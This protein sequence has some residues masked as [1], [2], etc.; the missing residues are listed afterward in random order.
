MIKIL[1]VEDE[2]EKRRLLV[3]TLIAVDGINHD[4][5]HYA[6]DVRAAKREIKETRFEL[7]ILDINIPMT[8][9]QEAETGAG[10]GVLSF[11]KNNLAAK[12][13]AF[14]VG[15]TSYDDGVAAAEKEFSSPLWKLVR[16]S[17]S[18]PTWQ[19][20]LQEAIKY[21][22]EKDAP[23]YISDGNTYHT[24]LAIFV[25]LEDE[26]LDSIRRLDG[27]WKERRIV[28]DNSRY[29]EGRFPTENG[30]ISV[31]AVAAPKMGLPAAAVIAS[32]LIAAYRPRYIA[33]TGICAGVRDKVAIGDILVAEPCFDWG[34][35]KWVRD[36]DGDLKFRP[37]P[38]PWRLDEKV[39]S[40]IKKLGENLTF[41]S[42][43][44]AAYY[45]SKP[46]KFPDLFVD[47]MASG[48][49]V[50]QVAKL[51]DDVREQHKNLVGIDMESYAVFTAAEYAS[52][53]RP[54]CFSIKSVCDFGDEDKSDA[55]HEYA[56]YMS[57]QFL[58]ELI[59]KSYL[60]FDKF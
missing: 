23:P 50:L 55:A 10:L 20:P 24:D 40:A 12:A 41:L 22:L 47:A 16:F 11:I 25:A 5:I 6:T 51:M 3:E 19:A 53:P 39:R 54:T 21:L 30:D 42:S 28:N 33:I 27:K 60:N 35:G 32:K 7:V 13:P 31:V 49:S 38:Y 57:A 15:M 14:V 48:G 37:A 56:A 26:E 8:P 58:F 45:A 29:F 1:V 46:S 59:T 17:H 43:A 18:E 36:K 9:D 44:H 52:E 4:N 2:K 34:S